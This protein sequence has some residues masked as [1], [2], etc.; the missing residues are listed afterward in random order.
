MTEE[1]EN[2]IQEIVPNADITVHPEPN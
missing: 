2:A 1:I